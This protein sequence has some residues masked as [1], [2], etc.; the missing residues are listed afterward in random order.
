[1]ERGAFPRIE[2]T[3]DNFVV[4]RLN[5]FVEGAWNNP[6]TPGQGLLIDIMPTVAG[7]NPLLFL[8][9]FSFDHLPTIQKAASDSNGTMSVGDSTQRWLTAFGTYVSGSSKVN[10]SF[11]NTFGGGFNTSIPMPTQDS[12]YGAGTLTVNDCNDLTL[13][14]DLPSGPG[15]GNV[16]LKRSA[17]DAVKLELCN[18]LGLM[19]GIIK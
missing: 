19:A 7:G 16:E 10:L 2:R 3:F 6:D 5:V 11:E 18:D 14:F 1:M 17:V 8:A 13:E 15:S 4:A 12:T 9:W